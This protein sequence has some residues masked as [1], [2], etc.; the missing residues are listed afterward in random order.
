MAHRVL[1]GHFF[2]EP[3]HFCPKEDFSLRILDRKIASAK[4]TLPSI[5]DDNG[6]KGTTTRS[7]YDQLSC[8]TKPWSKTLLTTAR[9]LGI[10]SKMPSDFLLS[11]SFGGVANT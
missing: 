9:F 11:S 8:E 5:L 6:N 2:I 4:G 1:A 3:D 10:Y 7:I